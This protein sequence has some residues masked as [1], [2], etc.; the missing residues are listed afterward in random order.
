MIMVWERY[1]NACPKPE[2][3]IIF[4]HISANISLFGLKFS[5]TVLH[6][7]KQVN[8]CTIDPFSLKFSQANTLTQYV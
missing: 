3:F 7:Q 4:I 1:C 8:R 6:V 5:Q 2:F